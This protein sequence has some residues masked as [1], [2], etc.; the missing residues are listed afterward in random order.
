MGTFTALETSKRGL[1]AQQY[2]L[3][4]TSNNINNVNTAGYSRRT[5]E[6]TET[7]P[8][9]SAQGYVGTGVTADSLRSYREEFFD[10][11]IRSSLARQSGYDTDEK[12]YEKVEAILAEPTKSGIGEVVQNFLSTFEDV[13]DNP[14][15]LSLRDFVVESAQTLTDRLHATASS[16]DATRNDV[17]SD[18]SA[19]VDSVNKL[20]SSIAELN[21]SIENEYASTGTAP[22]TYVDEREKDI[23]ELAEFTGATITQD[24]NAQ[25]NVY[26]NGV[27]VVTGRVASTLRLDKT[28][29]EVSGEVT[30][31]VSRVN[32]TGKVTE[33]VSPTSGSMASQL[34]SYNSLLDPVDSSSDYSVYTELNEYVNTL[35]E[36]INMISVSGYGLNDTGEIPPG[37]TFFDSSNGEITAANITVN[38]E[39]AADSAN[40]TL[41]DSAGEAGNN[42]KALEFARVANDTTFNAAGQTHAEVYAGILGKVGTQYSEAQ[43][44]VKTMQTVVDQLE[45]QRD[46]MI[47]VDL[48]EEAIDLVKYQKAYEASARVLN[49]TNEILQ[50]LINLGA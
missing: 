12:V 48:D 18:M 50:T 7:T 20:L 46:S 31:Q 28:V 24:D 41:S 14:Q 38:E 5:T 37:R 26:I 22:Q 25:V 32:S 36:K 44:G 13:A 4:V 45:S 40:L 29:N 16:L 8:S 47:G 6:M 19:D 23:E 34:K 11:E 1:M 3:N 27:N 15:N 2:A 21:K 33:S 17:L 49:T 9:S 10:K 42:V 39:I 43:S 35:A 30:A